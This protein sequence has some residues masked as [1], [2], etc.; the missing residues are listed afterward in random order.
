MLKRRDFLKLGAL[1]AGSAVAGEAVLSAPA[2]L[3]NP[4]GKDFSPATGKE[5][6]AIPSA[7]WQCVTR[8]PIIGY[9]ENGRLVKIEGQPYSIRSMGKVCAKGQAGVNQVNDPDRILYPLRRVGQRGEGKWKKVSWDEALTELATRLKTLRDQGHPEKFMFH[10]GRMKAS[11]SKI[12]KTFL[13]NYGTK[14]IAN[15]TNICE[16]G[17]WTAQELTWGYHYDNWDFDQTRYVLNFGSNCLEAHTNHVP[18]A[19][20]LVNA[21]ADRRVKLVTFDVRLA[22]TVAKSTEWVPIKPGTD[23]AVVLAMCHVIMKENLYRKEGE[24]FLKYCKATKDPNVSLDRKINS[25]KSHLVQYTPQWAEK[26]SGVPADDIKRIAIEFATTYP[27]VVISYRGAVAHY[28]GNE[29]ERA[30]QMLAA[31]TGNIDNPGGRCRGVGAHWKYP[32]GPEH[33][34]KAKKLDLIDGFKGQVAFPTHHVSHQ[35]LK[36]IKDGSQGRPDIYMWYC[37]QPVYSNGEVQ[38]NIDVLKDESL[39]PFTVAVSPFYDEAS[40]LADLILPDTTYLER[41]DWEDM[42]SP[43]QIGEYYIRQP[44]VKPFGEVRDFKD[45]CCELATRLGFPL[46]YDSAEDFVRQSCELTPTI[47]K[48]GGFEFMKKN[49]VWVDP[50]DKPS[51]FS[52]KKTI[53]PVLLTKDGVIFD[54]ATG[55]YWNWRKSKAKNQADAQ[56]KGYT[57]TKK[58]FKGYIGQKIGNAVY[59]GFTPDALNKSGYLELY[60]ILMEEKGFAPLPTYL[61]IPEHVNMKAD[62][63]IMTTYKV[64]VHS[65]SRTQNCKWLTEIYHENPAWINPVTAMERGVSQGDLITVKSSIGEI[66]TMA[67]VT[68]AIVPGVIAISNH[69][70]HWQYGQIAS[71]NSTPTHIEDPALKYKWWSDNGMHPNWII[72]S[73]P[74]P[75]NGQQRW[76]DTVVTVSKV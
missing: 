2:K 34:P 19:Q 15:H 43:L 60:S 11:S 16:G 51:Y 70:G 57:H 1:A 32:H 52:Y 9:V 72:P 22:N 61:P 65:H 29:T 74:D 14:T 55:V 23:G 13:A 50:D 75:I 42:V 21:I 27:A 48:A 30:I 36:L 63:L 73:T 39:I 8:C 37:Y 54:E 10:Y 6:Q 71:G 18:L 58:A 44:L 3:L 4:G 53:D 35:V 17:K 69:C 40:A 12:V 41:W 56:D 64:N 5:R 59:A 38:E 45:V 46:G 25:L 62:E 76:M 7:C 68:A 31:I 49:G 28:N 67:H 26:I 66:Q 24:A 47:K 20:R 33:T